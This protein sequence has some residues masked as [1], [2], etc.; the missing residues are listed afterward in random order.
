M[1]KSVFGLVCGFMLFPLLVQAGQGDFSPSRSGID[2]TTHDLGTGSSVEFN[3]YTDNYVLALSRRQGQ[4]DARYQDERDFVTSRKILADPGADK[5]ARYDH[6]ISN[7]DLG[8]QVWVQVF[9]HNNATQVC[10][11]A[12]PA[13]NTRVGLDWANPQQVEAFVSADNASPARIADK[14]SY[15]FRG[16]YSFRLVGGVEVAERIDPDATRE[17]ICKGHGADKLGYRFRNLAS[18]GSGLGV[19]TN[20][21]TVYGSFGHVKAVYFKLEVVPAVRSLEIIKSAQPSGGVGALSEI[22][23]SLQVRNTG[24]VGLTGVKL[25]DL[26]DSNLDYVAGGQ[27]AQGEV[28][29]DIGSLTTQTVQRGFS[30]RVKDSVGPGLE[31]CNEAFGAADQMETIIS[32][33]VCQPVEGGGGSD[34]NF[35]IFKRYETWFDRDGNG[36]LSGGDE[37]T[38]VV[39]VQNSSPDA[40]LRQVVIT[41]LPG[42]GLALMTPAEISV[43]DLPVDSGINIRVK[44]RV[45][46]D[47][48]EG[49]QVC[50]AASVTGIRNGVG[51]F[52]SENNPTAPVCHV[53]GQAP[54]QPDSEFAIEKKL[55]RFEDKNGDGALNPGETIFYQIRVANTGSMDLTETQL[56][57]VGGEHLL[58][59]GEDKTGIFALG[60]LGA[61]AESI[62]EV[63]VMVKSTVPNGTQVCNTASVLAFRMG[64]L[65]H[66]ALNNPTEPVCVPVVVGGGGGRSGGGGGGAPSHPTIGACAVMT[67]GALQCVPRYPVEDLDDESY[68]AYRAC[69]KE[70]DK[71][72]RD[73]LIEWSKSR[74][75]YTCGDGVDGQIDIPYTGS[76]N[77]DLLTQCGDVIPNIGDG[78]CVPGPGST[79][80][81]KQVTPTIVS[82]GEKVRYRVDLMIDGNG[83]PVINRGTVKVYDF[84]VPSATGGVWNRNGFLSS[85]WGWNTG[86][87]YYVREL[88]GGEVDDLNA[89]RSIDLTFEYDMDTEL[90]AQ[91]DV[92]RV[93]N[94][95][96]AVLEYNGG[97]IGIGNNVCVIK[98]L[99]QED[100]FT[101]STLG[102]TAELSIVRPFIE[103]RG[104]NVGL[105]FEKGEGIERVTGDKGTVTGGGRIST[106]E[107]Y[108]ERDEDRSYLTDYTGGSRGIVDLSGVANYTQ[109]RDM[110]D[111]YANL[112]INLDQGLE[113]R[114]L[115]TDFRSSRG[116]ANIFF[117][118]EEK[119]DRDPVLSGVLNFGGNSR[120][121]VI[122][123]R[124]LIIGDTAGVRTDYT[125][126][127]Y[128]AFIVRNGNIRIRPHVEH[129]EGIFVVEN[130]A[131]LPTEYHD[132]SGSHP[133]VSQRPL[134]VSGMLVGNVA[135]LLQYR[136]FIGEDPT[137]KLE[138]NVVVDFDH[139]ILEQTPPVLERVLGSGWRQS[140]SN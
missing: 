52:P 36:V 46:P 58:L 74:D 108:V 9:V 99:S 116:R 75:F 27:Y 1:R 19:E 66:P 100:V 62:R 129:I 140:V 92:A 25:K 70:E 114:Q 112:K 126:N 115:G 34:R 23:Y 15:Y 125:I 55:D 33:T 90:V 132:Q 128:A 79:N 117:L 10:G 47:L 71:E 98:S 16:D 76:Q 45:N 50:N 113:V 120:T 111:F 118:D 122:E 14:V 8:D 57:D 35:S 64:Q 101:R 56:V 136:R 133:E 42:N 87:R 32:N 29:F 31:V 59:L 49:E 18:T 4:N 30:V 85:G 106:G 72:I 97:R 138:P 63:Q 123:G 17:E 94:V 102:A 95:A 24:N 93:K 104:G 105:G 137:T 44:G 91:Y 43:G 89:N 81:T 109:G 86:G 11:G 84:T 124:D 82:K 5:S 73:C 38:Y 28:R 110:D 107:V 37:I 48:N 39:G 40:G 2:R 127:G 69:V 88:N 60:T 103:G 61:G 54:S 68:L 119:A 135:P 21:G 134:K 3:R 121:Y 130:G 67:D 77:A 13:H 65:V 83:L 131:I 12:N 53:L 80:L 51:V 139:R 78:A 20:L 41:D 7:L 22:N 26:L 96:F 6:S